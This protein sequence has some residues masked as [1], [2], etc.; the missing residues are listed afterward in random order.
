GPLEQHAAAE[1]ARR[2]PC[3]LGAPRGDLGR[4]GAHQPRQLPRVRGQQRRRP[5]LLD[6]LRGI[7]DEREPVG[8][9]QDRQVRGEHRRPRARGPRSLSTGPPRPTPPRTRP[10]A[11]SP[12]RAPRLTVTPAPAQA[13]RTTPT[14]ASAATGRPRPAPPRS[15]PPT[16]SAAAPVNRSLPATTPRTPRRYL[17]DS[18]PG[19][20]NNAATSL[21][22]YATAAGA[23]RQGARPMSTS[24]ASPARPAPGSIT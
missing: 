5:A 14:A 10:A 19:T 6:Q 15:A 18:R 11:P 20:G 21:A 23:G 8:V 17:S 16:A 24:W 1:R 9:H 2:G 13:C 22:P 3:V 4:V 7:G 12:P